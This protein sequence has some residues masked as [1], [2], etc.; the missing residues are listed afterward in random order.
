MRFRV[1][2]KATVKLWTDVEA[3]S[4][5]E[6][7]ELGMARFCVQPVEIFADADP[8]EEWAAEDVDAM[9]EITIDYPIGI[10]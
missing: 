7:R 2:D 8:E 3:G 6:A 4:L 5:D 9:P 10:S 1:E